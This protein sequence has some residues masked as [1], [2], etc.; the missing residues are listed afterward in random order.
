MTPAMKPGEALIDFIK[1]VLSIFTDANGKIK[2]GKFVITLIVASIAG[3][4]YHRN[5]IKDYFATTDK[6]KYIQEYRKL[7][8]EVRIKAFDSAI[9]NQ[10]R[11][12]YTMFN[13]DIISVYEYIP[14]DLHFFKE[15]IH[16]EGKLP[17]GTDLDTYK[18]LSVIKY[19]E[20]Y[21]SHISGMSY[22][23]KD[24]ESFVSTTK[25]DEMYYTY[26][27]PIFNMRGVY[28]GFIRMYWLEN[29]NLDDNILFASCSGS[30]RI[31]GSSMKSQH[32]IKTIAK[33]INAEK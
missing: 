20:E 33:T 27:C 6:A 2:Y 4:Y 12:L 26:S 18:N 13:T 21:K 10:T 3:A 23:S 8:E 28:N 32:E 9:K 19:S 11:M 29:P 16:Y 15:I 1:S 22:Q 31:I 30:A 17:A 24:K 7:E 5:E 25:T 14:E